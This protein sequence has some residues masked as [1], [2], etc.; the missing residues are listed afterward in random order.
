[1]QQIQRSA[2]D[3]NQPDLTLADKLRGEHAVDLEIKQLP[4]LPENFS[5]SPSP[6]RTDRYLSPSPSTPGR[7]KRADKALLARRRC[8]GPSAAA[9]LT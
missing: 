6:G 9:S 1:M 3:F 2:E 8:R 4:H 7:R 5:P